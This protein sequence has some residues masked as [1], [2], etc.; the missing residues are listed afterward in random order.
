VLYPPRLIVLDLEPKRVVLND[1][2]HHHPESQLLPTKKIVN[3]LFPLLPLLTRLFVGYL[4]LY[5][6]MLSVCLLL[7]QGVRDF[8]SVVLLYLLVQ[9]L[10]RTSL[11]LIIKHIISHRLLLRF[12]LKSRHRSQLPWSI[13]TPVLQ[14][15]VLKLSLPLADI[16]FPGQRERRV[17][18]SPQQ[19]LL[20]HLDLCP[21]HPLG[22]MRTS[23]PRP[24]KRT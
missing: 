22:R 14:R 19:P 6:Y 15:Q 20:H 21:G 18:D 23:S 11:N 5:H 3:Q 2:V 9:G 4:W 13:L 10:S 16:D 1:P 7:D 17:L 24:S 8:L 12:K